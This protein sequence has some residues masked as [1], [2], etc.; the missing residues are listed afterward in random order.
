MTVCV[1]RELLASA[2][3]SF[4][5]EITD[6]DGVYPSRNISPDTRRYSPANAKLDW[7]VMNTS[8]G[9]SARRVIGL[10]GWPLP[11]KIISKSR[12]TPSFK[13]IESPGASVVN[14]ARYSSWLSTRYSVAKATLAKTMVNDKASP[15]RT[16]IRLMVNNFIAF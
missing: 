2:V 1:T 7:P 15:C 9:V 13:I 14:T 16:S 4:L 8:P 3:L 5:K 10:P 11:S 6:C 12:Q